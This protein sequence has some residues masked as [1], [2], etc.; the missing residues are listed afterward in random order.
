MEYIIEDCLKM[1]DFLNFCLPIYNDKKI[2]TF[3]FSITAK[4]IKN[5]FRT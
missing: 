2:N 5:G 4:L 1:R 3:K